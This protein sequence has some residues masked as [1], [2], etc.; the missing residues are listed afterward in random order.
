MNLDAELTQYLKESASWDADRVRLAQRSAHRA[1]ALTTLFGLL[2]TAACAAVAV[3]TPLKTTE[4]FVIRVDNTT[5]VIDVVPTYTGN[6]AL[7]DTVTR[8]LLMHYVTTC[9][10][11]TETTAEQD[12]TECGTFHSPRRNQEWAAHWART[13]PDSPINRFRD[14]SSLLVHVQAIS[15]FK[16]SNGLTDLAQ[17]RYATTHRE[18][19]G[20]EVGVTHWIVTVQYTYTAPSADPT[21]RRWNPLGFRILDF[22]AEPELPDAPNPSATPPATTVATAATTPGTTP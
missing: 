4:P 7:N 17:V 9:E 14:G 16:R 22:H 20:G 8:F 1:W 21:Q 12:Y 13:N 18:P 10:R 5:G 6:A 2:A 3:L 11:Y 15:F 19:G